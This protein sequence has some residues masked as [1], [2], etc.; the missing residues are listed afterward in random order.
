MSHP[1]PLVSVICLCHNQA[2]FVRRALDS[3]L[4]QTYAP[5]EL[6]VVDD[7]STDGSPAVIQ[8]FLA[9][10]PS[11]KAFF[12]DKNW[13]NCRAF[14]HALGQARGAFI[15]DLAADDVLLPERVARQVA[16]FQTVASQ[17]GVLFHNARLIDENGDS[18]GTYFPVDERGRSRVLVPEGDV[19]AALLHYRP[20]CS[21]TMLI[22]RDV[23]D[24]LGGYDETLAYEDFDFWM[25]SS[26]KWLYAY[27]DEVLT[28]KRVRS[29]S[30][31]GRLYQFR[32]DLL[33][34]AF[35]VCQKADALVRTP[36]ERAALDFRLRYFVR[37]CWYTGHFEIAGAFAELL[38]KTDRLTRLVLLACRWW[39]PVHSAYG[40][41]RR[42]KRFWRGY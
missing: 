33:P 15:L 21:P 7:A 34:S 30:L 10:N 36:D 31:G 32:N 35:L 18:L 37:Q 2:R 5:V 12:L 9:E 42:W 22:R 40:Q 26:R 38:P 20:V 17:V 8:R 19:F 41:Y 27:Q 16:G 24:E 1:A 13:G 25:R 39:V 6:L 28:E 4:A 14:N 29:N 11:V 3:V 23:L